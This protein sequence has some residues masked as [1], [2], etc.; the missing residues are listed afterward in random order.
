MEYGVARALADEEAAE[1][2]RWADLSRL[3][4]KQTASPRFSQLADRRGD[5]DRAETARQ[6][7]RS[8]G[9]APIR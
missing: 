9:L 1:D 7:E 3:V 4:R 5:H 6:W 8:H 2:R